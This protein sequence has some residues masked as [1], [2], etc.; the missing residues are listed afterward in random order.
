[1]TIID[2]FQ[3]CALTS[4]SSRIHIQ[5]LCPISINSAQQQYKIFPSAIR[6]QNLTILAKRQN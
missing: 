2:Y 4:T 3:Y 5:N 1:M 6:T